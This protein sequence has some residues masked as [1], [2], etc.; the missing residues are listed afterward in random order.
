MELLGASGRRVEAGGRGGARRRHWLRSGVCGERE[1]EGD[2]RRRVSARGKE[3]RGTTREIQGVEGE[4]Q[5]GGGRSSSAR[6]TP[7][8][9]LLAEE[10]EDKGEGG[11]GRPDGLASWASSGG[12]HGEAR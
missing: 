4:R 10:E 1:E 8:L 11:L 2:E 6:A 3:V 5:A 12:L 9:C 7:R